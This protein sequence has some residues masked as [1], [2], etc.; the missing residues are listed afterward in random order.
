[1]GNV[2]S[3]D[4]RFR[5]LY[6]ENYADIR[7]YCLRRLSVEEANDAASE[8]FIVAWRK[9]DKVPQGAEA[10]LWLFAVARNIVA[11]QHRSRSQTTRLRSKLEQNA[12][13]SRAGSPAED[14]VVRRSQDQAVIDALGRM[15]PDDRELIR[16]KMWEELSHAEIGA[17]F[18]I[19]AHAVDMRM[20]RVGK[21]LARVLS[22]AKG[23]RPQAISEGGEL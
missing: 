19:S 2:P 22:A 20:Q 14:V 4:T 5:R 1:M 12:V 18:G 9:I 17:V 23:V 15:K 21:R 13:R 6:E 16:L 10:R 3:S 8:I 7:S 11:H